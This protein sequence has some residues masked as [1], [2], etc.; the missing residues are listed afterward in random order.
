MDSWNVASWAISVAMGLVGLVGGRLWARVRSSAVRRKRTAKLGALQTELDAQRLRG[1]QL[2][3]EVHAQRARSFALERELEARE[4]D[5]AQSSPSPFSFDAQTFQ[6]ERSLPTDAGP[7]P[8][9]TDRIADLERQVHDL[10][11]LVAKVS[12]RTHSSRTR[13]PQLP[14]NPPDSRRTAAL[15]REAGS[16]EIEG[17]N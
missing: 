16:V 13:S 1:N 6:I 14:R 5:W 10:Q 4:S 15:P 7:R 3:A 12:S 17:T 8:Q 2:E 11:D 9:D